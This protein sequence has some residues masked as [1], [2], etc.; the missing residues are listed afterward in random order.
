MSFLKVAKE[1]LRAKRAVF[2]K[3]VGTPLFPLSRFGNPK[4]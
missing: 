1:F 2:G 3:V 4:V